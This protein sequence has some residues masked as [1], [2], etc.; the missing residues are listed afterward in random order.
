MRV[1]TSERERER[2]RGQGAQAPA[3]RGQ[4]PPIR[5]EGNRA[6]LAVAEQGCLC[7]REEDRGR[8]RER[9]RKR[10]RCDEAPSR[11]TQPLVHSIQHHAIVL[12]FLLVVV[13]TMTDMMQTHKPAPI[14]VEFQ[15]S[16]SPIPWA[17]TDTA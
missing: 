4:Y 10:H 5:G 6:A 2:E 16:P 7:G 14:H 1:S 15:R 11:L 13:M 12:S 17:F 9:G 8:V 3:A